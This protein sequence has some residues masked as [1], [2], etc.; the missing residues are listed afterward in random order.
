MIWQLCHILDTSSTT[1]RST[2]SHLLLIIQLSSEPVEPLAEPLPG[3]RTAAL[4]VP[5]VLT[6]LVQGKQV[7]EVARVARG[8]EIDLVS[9]YEHD[10]ILE[11]IV[12]EE[13]EELHLAQ[14]QVLRGGLRRI[15]HIYHCLR[16]LVVCIPC[17]SQAF[18]PAQ[19]PH[20]QLH[21]LMCHLL[22]IR[23]DCRLSYHHLV[24]CKFVKYCGFPG[25]MQADDD[26][27]ILFILV[28]ETLPQFGQEIT[29]YYIITRI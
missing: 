21:I 13:V 18:L 7:S 17:R 2:S 9:E 22:H 12:V 24:Q 15:H 29:H 11:V 25:V 3:Q 28:Y 14:Q 1:T 10:S 4:D 6:D 16:V 27:L 26:N 20:L 23:P 19:V 5:V 8:R